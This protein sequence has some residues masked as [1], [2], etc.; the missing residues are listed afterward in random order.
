MHFSIR[1]HSTSQIKCFRA[2]GHTGDHTIRDITLIA[3]CSN[4]HNASVFGRGEHTYISSVHVV[5][6]DISA[7]LDHGL[8]SLV[9]KIDINETPRDHNF[10]FSVG[11]TCGRAQPKALLCRLEMGEFQRQNHGDLIGFS[12]VARR[13]TGHIPGVEILG[14]NR[15]YI[16][17]GGRGVNNAKVNVRKISGNNTGGI[18]KLATM[19]HDEVVAFKGIIPEDF[20]LLLLP[21]RFGV[22]KLDPALFCG[23]LNALEPSL[24]PGV[25]IY[26]PREQDCNSPRTFF[27][28]W[29]FFSRRCCCLASRHSQSQNKK[30]CENNFPLVLHLKFLLD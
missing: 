15:A 12:H 20:L 2:T 25:V 21:H 1:V 23:S 13:H 5:D 17:S 28:R 24:I 8:G 4:A 30:G 27:C 16:P 29:S 10:D 22:G 9:S 7:A 14:H 11:S 18:I 26:N 3:I 6:Q 19:P